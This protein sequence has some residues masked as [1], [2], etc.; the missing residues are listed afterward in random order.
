[1]KR[2]TPVGVTGHYEYIFSPVI[3]ADGTVEA[4]AGSTRD[5]TER[6]R[7]EAALIEARQAAENAN[8]TKD[9]FL[10][11]LSHELR[12]PL[13]PM[14]MAVAALEHDS[15]LRPAVREHLAMI[16]RNIQL[17]TKLI[18]DLLDLSRITSGKVELEIEAL[19][20][21]ETV[22]RVCRS[23]RSQMHEQGI[24]LEIDLSDAVALIAADSARLQQVLW[25]VLMNAIKFTPENGTIRVTTTRLAGGRWEVRVQ[26][27]GIGISMEALPRIFDAYEQG[28]VKVTR[29]FGG[30]GLGLA[31]SKSLLELHRGSIRAESSGP[32]QGSTFIVELP[33]KEADAVG[34]TPHFAPAESGK[35]PQMR[36]LLVENH[37]DTART[38][39]RL[40]RSAG[41]EVITA[42]DVASASAAAQ[43][44]SFHV[45]VSDLGLP[46][47]D[48]YEIM[49]R[50]RAIRSMPGIAMSGYGMNEDR[51]RSHEAGFSEHLVKPI[52]ASQLIAAI[53][54]VTDNRG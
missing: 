54:R 1:M 30:L 37:P 48:G 44:E 45:L 28:G 11:V 24:R 4:V 29:Q 17:E 9:R 52:D 20:L 15:E 6:K 13:T 23:C 47:G 40:L 26:D 36:V 50:I 5:I 41:F 22:R 38:I 10:A 12:T 33:G 16:K 34:E 39:S 49:R 25:N 51:R 32:G 8:Q 53:R 27:S 46:D 21:N 2:P 35:Q 3:A 18:D 14:L 43:G 7:V 19:D 31:I 42:S